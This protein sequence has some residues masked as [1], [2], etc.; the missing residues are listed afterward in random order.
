V[1]V[2]LIGPDGIVKMETVVD[3]AD[4][5]DR[6]LVEWEDHLWLRPMARRREGIKIVSV[7]C[8]LCGNREIAAGRLI[9]LERR[10]REYFVLQT[11]LRRAAPGDGGVYDPIDIIDHYFV[12]NALPHVSPTA[13]CRVHGYFDVSPLKLR[14]LRSEYISNPERGVRR[15]RVGRGERWPSHA[16][17][18]GPHSALELD[19]ESS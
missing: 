11:R 4:E 2:D 10:H 6:R 17:D 8:D 18:A 14:D 7:V 19:S 3:D 1:I 12:H 15:L 5:L 9:W 16:A 13:Y